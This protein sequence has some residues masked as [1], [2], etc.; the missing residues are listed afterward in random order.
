[1]LVK[2]RAGLDL[3]AEALLEKETI[4]GAEVARLLQTAMGDTTVAEPTAA[5]TSGN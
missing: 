4:D 5:P 3:V 1:L 2:H